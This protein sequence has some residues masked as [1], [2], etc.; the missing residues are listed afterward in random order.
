MAHNEESL[1]G[2]GYALLPAARQKLLD[3][4]IEA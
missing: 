2:I 1:M 3:L 4:R